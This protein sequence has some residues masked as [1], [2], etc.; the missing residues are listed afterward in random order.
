MRASDHIHTLHRSPFAFAPL[1]HSFYDEWE[2]IENDVLLSYLIVPLVAY[3]PMHTFLGRAKR[4]SSLR[5][6]T[7]DSSRFF[8]LSLRIKDFK[9]ITN[10]A[11]LILTAEK[12]L[13][14]NLEMSAV[15]TNKI[16][17]ANSNNDLLKYSR[18]LAMVFA[19]EDV[20]SIYRM[21]GIKAL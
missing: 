8:G 17:S 1:I 9:S 19:G 5:T 10:A 13:E 3:K 21:L 6:M 16:R 4:S 15:S 7:S 20:I 14:I 18:K 11:L 2:S 12:A